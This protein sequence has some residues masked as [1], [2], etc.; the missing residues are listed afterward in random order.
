MSGSVRANWHLADLDLGDLDPTPMSLTDAKPIDLSRTEAEL[1]G[2]LVES[3]DREAR[4]FDYAH[5][6]YDAEGRGV[7]GPLMCELK[8]GDQHRMNGG[9]L[10]CFECPHHTTSKDDPLSLI[11]VLGRRQE[12]LVGEI[13][14]IQSHG[15]LDAALVAAYEADL[16]AAD[17]MADAVLVAA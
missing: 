4:Y 7:G 12:E 5:R 6:S 15:A 9:D 11:C 17:E 2:E 8:F 16:I 3:L 14:A 13:H 10:S 1:H